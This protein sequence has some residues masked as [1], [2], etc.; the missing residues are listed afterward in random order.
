MAPTQLLAQSS[1][2]TVEP[3]PALL[4]AALV[5]LGA[6]AVLVTWLSR[7]NAPRRPR[8][9]PAQM[10]LTGSE[11]PAIAGMLTN[12]FE[13]PSEAATATLLDLAARDW[14]RIDQ[15]GED[16]IL[17]RTRERPPAANGLAPYEERVLRHVQRKAIDGSAPAEALTTGP[18]KQAERWWRGF[19]REVEKDAKRRGLARPRWTLGALA[20][21]WA[22]TVAALGAV[23]LAFQTGDRVPTVEASVDPLAGVA[24]LGALVLGWYAARVTRAGHQRDTDQGLEVAGRWLGVRRWLDEQGDFGEAPAASVAIWDRYLPYATAFALAPT[25]ERELP[26]GQEHDRRAWSNASGTWRQVRVAY[27]RW[28]PGWGEHPFRALVTGALQAAVAGAIAVGGFVVWTGRTDA[29]DDVDPEA[30]IW[31]ERGAMVVALVLAPV[32]LYAAA[33]AVAGLVDLL[34][35]RRVE[36]LVIRRRAIRAGDWIP[37]P[38]RLLWYSFSRSS[39]PGTHGSHHHRRRPSEVDRYRRVRWWVALDD[40]EQAKVGAYQVRPAIYR[41]APQGARVRLSVSPILGYVKDVEVLEAPPGGER[42]VPSQV[43]EQLAGA[44]AGVADRWLSRTEEQLARAPASPDAPSGPSV[45]D[46]TD[47][48]G[49]PVRERLAEARRRLDR[50]GLGDAFGGVLERSE[51]LLDDLPA[52]EE[53]RD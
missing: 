40:G 13:V 42:A 36:G 22:A 39:R 10:E 37:R 1:S 14:V 28:R 21:L 23:G 44:A 16:R 29:L 24:I 6:A 18:D 53:R 25:V 48:E 20:L 33:K 17:V 11:P 4:V 38:L 41:R 51:R 50:S 34:P 35:R 45:L 8:A 26:M 12:R 19:R 49:V 27:P 30:L 9:A 2:T 43:T 31:I 46:Q 15:V 3:Q 5:V 32:A 47:E 52:P 7:T